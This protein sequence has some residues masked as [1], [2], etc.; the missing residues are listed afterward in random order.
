VIVVLMMQLKVFLTSST[1][2]R[3]AKI[4]SDG[5]TAASAGDDNDVGRTI[6]SGADDKCVDSMHYLSLMYKQK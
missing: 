2:L 3:S 4:S 6:I 1:N 5:V